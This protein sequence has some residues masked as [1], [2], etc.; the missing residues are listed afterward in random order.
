MVHLYTMSRS[1]SQLFDVTGKRGVITGAGG[2]LCGTMAE[3]LAAFGAEVALLDL[4]L[5]KAEERAAAIRDGGGKATAYQ[6]DVLD[7][8]AIEKVAER[9]RSSWDGI[10]FL[11][12]GA[13]GN[14]P[15]ATTSAPFVEAGDLE[16]PEYVDFSRIPEASFR[17]VFDLNYMGTILPT[18]VF[19]ADMARAGRGSIINISSLNAINPLTKIPAYATGKAAVASFTKWLAVHY[20][21]L[22]VRVN[23]I[24]PGFFMTEQLRFLHTDQSTGEPTERSKEIIAQTPFRR[25]GDPEEL[26]GTVV[27]LLTEA[28]SFVTGTLIPV[29]GGYAVYSI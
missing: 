21:H 8:G 20:A 23:A 24:A 16:D 29:D 11:I 1:T 25:Y 27:W 6:C 22:G 19:G 5:E 2:E 12:N 10:D 28:S 26:V 18:Q 14:H 4:N 7:R 13:G 9:I 17:K 15:S 3:H